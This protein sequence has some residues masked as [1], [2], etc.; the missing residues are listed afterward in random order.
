[1]ITAPVP[2]APQLKIAPEGID[3]AVLKEIGDIDPALLQKIVT[4]IVAAQKALDSEY[5]RG[6]PPAGGTAGPAT[7]RPARPD[8]DPDRLR[9]AHVGRRRDE[10]TYRQLAQGLKHDPLSRSQA[11]CCGGSNS[12]KAYR[13]PARAHRDA[14]CPC[15]AHA[16]P[17]RDEKK[18]RPDA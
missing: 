12:P 3:P 14:Y 4:A 8:G 18:H 9:A 6:G 16:G 15:A 11:L 1:M 13:S 5:R 2:P 17:G 10:E 7:R